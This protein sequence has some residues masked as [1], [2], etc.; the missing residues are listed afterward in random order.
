[1]P[2]KLPFEP[3]VAALVSDAMPGTAKVLG[4][5]Q[6][7]RR[8][9]SWPL[10]AR[11]TGLGSLHGGEVILAP[12][13]RASPLLSS[14]E[15]MA[16]AGVAALVVSEAAVGEPSSV[17][18]LPIIVVPRATDMRR[19]RTELEGYIIRRRRELFELG[20][21]SHRVLVDVALGGGEVRKLMEIAAA[22]SGTI[23]LLDRG[24]TVDVMPQGAD[25]DELSLS[26]LRNARADGALSATGSS[27]V[28]AFPIVAGGERLG[29][30]ALIDIPCSASDEAE[31]LLDTLAEAC[32]I[33]MTRR[34][35]PGPMPLRDLLAPGRRQLAGGT[36]SCT[37]LALLDGDSASRIARAVEVE[38]SLRKIQVLIAREDQTIVGL[39][40]GTACLNWD[41]IVRCVGVRLGTST[42]RAGVSR[43]H[44]TATELKQ[45][46]EEALHAAERSPPGTVIRYHA[47]ELDVLLGRL[48]GIPGFIEAR[49]GPL[50]VP[51]AGR[52][53]LLLTLEAYLASGRNVSASARTLG[54]H[55]NTLHYRL[56]RLRDLLQ[57]DLDCADTT[58]GLDLALR[59]YRSGEALRSGGGID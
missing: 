32:A 45:V 40:S 1:M 6:A 18:P 46:V 2:E 13:A 51:G 24:G 58:F 22:R 38:F 56:H 55:R 48:A 27:R 36:G 41:D 23:V 12:D 5:A 29:L 16:A 33:A 28:L 14:L 35:P 57:A 31:I 21:E 39:I 26:E 50:L 25:L 52:R 44:S 53:E 7:L 3:S 8:R 15:R 54:V 42:L 59:C 37:A 17:P 43:N 34:P 47:I 11:A 10:L 19:L 49:L 4:A 9:V 30:V 20:Q